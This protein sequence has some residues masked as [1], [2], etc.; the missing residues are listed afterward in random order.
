M[1]R[2]GFGIHPEEDDPPVG[3]IELADRI[4]S[5]GGRALAL[6]RDPVGNHWQIFAMLPRERCSPLPTSAIFRKLMPS[7]C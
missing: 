3:V 4:E 7:G 1:A 2:M 5:D 6:Y